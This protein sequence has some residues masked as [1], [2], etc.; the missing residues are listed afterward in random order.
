MIMNW[1]TIIAGAILF[2][3]PYVTGYSD[4]TP[5]LWTSLIMGAAI[6]I[7]GFMQS[8]KWA[9]VAGLVTSIVPFVLGFSGIALWICL[10]VGGAVAILDGYRGFFL[11]R[12]A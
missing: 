3:A 12:T 6:A 4:T 8:Y 10:I 5:A 9:A 7:F 1:V 11:T 2:V